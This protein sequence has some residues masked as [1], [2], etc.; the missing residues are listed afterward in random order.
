METS[1]NKNKR[2]RRFGKLSIISIVMAA[3]GLASVGFITT[4]ASADGDGDG[5][6]GT[7]HH[8]AT[9]EDGNRG[10]SDKAK[11]SYHKGRL[12]NLGTSSAATAKFFEF[13]DD[14]NSARAQCYRDSASSALGI[15][16]AS[17]SLNIQSNISRDSVSIVV[18]DGS[19]SV[20]ITDELMTSFKSALGD[21]FETNKEAI[22][23]EARAKFGKFGKELTEKSLTGV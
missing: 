16:I 20:T 5:N 3:L 4:S 18:S 23:A 7:S 9:N 22:V 21:C 10:N 13:I 11:R 14:E 15:D 2:F 8:A 12:F 19:T 17:Q 6:R 1:D